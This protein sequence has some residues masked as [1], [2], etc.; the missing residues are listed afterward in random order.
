[1]ELYLY[2]PICLHDASYSHDGLFSIT[3][4]RELTVSKLTSL[5]FG[6]V[7]IQNSITYLFIVL[8]INFMELQTQRHEGIMHLSSRL[9][10]NELW[11]CF[12][13]TQM[14]TLKT[15]NNC[16][17]RIK[18]SWCSRE[19]YENRTRTVIKYELIQ[20]GAKNLR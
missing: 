17:P 19:S 2:F 6:T 5:R 3:G 10:S 1:M 13:W 14:V 9:G 20:S 7:F 12:A 18:S 15:E 4:G 16:L 11:L 8:K